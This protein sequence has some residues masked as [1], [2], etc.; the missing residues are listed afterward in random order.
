MQRVLFNIIEGEIVYE[1]LEMTIKELISLGP[2]N[3]SEIKDALRL[4]VESRLE[5]LGSCEYIF[6]VEYSGDNSTNFGS[7]SYNKAILNRGT[8]LNLLRDDEV[9]K[10]KF[11][12]DCLEDEF[13]K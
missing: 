5:N 10:I 7:L 6:S 3:S 4:E 9:I 1:D 12:I 13:Y 8:S 2:E 11:Y